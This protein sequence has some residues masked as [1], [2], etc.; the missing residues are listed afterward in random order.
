M[1]SISGII[2]TWNQLLYPTLGLKLVILWISNCLQMSFSLRQLAWEGFVRFMFQNVSFV[3]DFSL[4]L[5]WMWIIAIFRHFEAKCVFCLGSRLK[6]S[7]YQEIWIIYH[8]KNQNCEL[9]SISWKAH[10]P[11]TTDKRYA[12]QVWIRFI[13]L[14]LMA[15]LCEFPSSTLVSTHKISRPNVPVSMRSLFLTII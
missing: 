7:I 5:S 10:L 1:H 8:W 4:I 2:P 6:L 12:W 9:R 15:K 3:G 13:A 14:S 11:H